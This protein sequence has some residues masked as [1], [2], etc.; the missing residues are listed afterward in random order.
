MPFMRVSQF[1]TCRAAVHS[2]RAVVA[3]V[4]V[5]DVGDCAVVDIVDPR[6]TE[7]VVGP[8]VVVTAVVPVTACESYANVAESIIDAT[9]I[10][11]V[12]AP[13]TPIEHIGAI[14][15][16]PVTRRPQGTDV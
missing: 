1:L 10:T 5:G 16:A 15:P 12:I 3:V 6:A 4:V 8:V 9:V 2:A 11:D 7:I 13:V 14:V